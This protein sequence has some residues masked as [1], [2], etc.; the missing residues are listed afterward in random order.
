[1]FSK[2]KIFNSLIIFNY[3]ANVPSFVSIFHRNLNDG[4]D[5]IRRTPISVAPIVAPTPL[6]F[7]EIFRRSGHWS[8]RG[9][10]ASDSG[11]FFNS[12]FPFFKSIIEPR[13]FR[14]AINQGI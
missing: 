8:Q 10:V 6:P 2:F 13:V 3:S 1:M 9:D 7:Q 12:E 5:G 4:K 14:V 11:R